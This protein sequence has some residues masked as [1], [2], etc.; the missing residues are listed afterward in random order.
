MR[1]NDILF[2]GALAGLAVGATACHILIQEV[3]KAVKR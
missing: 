2:Y 1:L 3:A